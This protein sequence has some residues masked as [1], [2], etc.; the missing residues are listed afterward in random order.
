MWQWMVECRMLA[1]GG[2]KC[3]R[4]ADQKRNCLQDN[5]NCSTQKTAGAAIQVEMT[6]PIYFGEAWTSRHHGKLCPELILASQRAEA[7]K[8]WT[9]LQWFEG[10]ACAAMDNEGSREAPFSMATVVSDW[11]WG[12]LHFSMVQHIIPTLSLS[13]TGA[14]GGHKHL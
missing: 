7:S 14:R 5:G 10:S 13:V 9:C 12:T 6:Y 11:L 2:T 4:H 8:T 1:G 3:S